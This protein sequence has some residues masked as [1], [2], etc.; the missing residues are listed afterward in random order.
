MQTEDEMRAEYLRVMGADLGQWYY[1]LDQEIDWLFLKWSVFRDLFKTGPERNQM[2]NTAAPNFF[3]ILRRLLYEDAMLHLCRL[4]DP[5][6]TFGKYENLTVLRL[7]EQ[8]SDPSLKD[9]LKVAAVYAEKECEF[10][11]Q[12]RDKRLAHTDVQV[13]RGGISALPPVTPE[14]VMN[15]IQA[16]RKVL[17]LVREHYNLPPSASLLSDPWGATAL[18]HYLEAGLHAE[19]KS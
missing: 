1:E 19:N 10:A 16:I 7:F 6:K 5:P 18:V 13:F 3:H 4:T 14:S 17:N 8:V 11:R 9:S 2:L 15:A 12:W